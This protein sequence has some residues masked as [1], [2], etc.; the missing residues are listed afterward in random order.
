MT[1]LVVLGLGLVAGAE[2][3]MLVVQQRRYVLAISGV[4]VGLVLLGFRRLLARDLAPDTL[5]PDA[6]VGDSLRHWVSRTETLIHWSEATRRDWD[7]HWRPMLARRYENA[8]GQSRAKDLTA[9]TATG[10]MLFGDELWQW[11][12][13]SNVADSGAA[14]P[15]PGRA[16]LEE[17]LRRLEQA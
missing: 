16:V 4:S 2:L 7:R 14:E 15:G 17:I 8:T 5:S 1:R 6:T 12:D 3:L 11:V 10:R 9:F 13:P